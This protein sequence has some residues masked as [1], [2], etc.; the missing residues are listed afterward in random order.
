MKNDLV[1]IILDITKTSSNN[2]L[3]SEEKQT[4]TVTRSSSFFCALTK[5]PRE[6]SSGSNF[7]RELTASVT[8]GQSVNCAFR[9]STDYENSAEAFGSPHSSP[10]LKASPLSKSVFSLK[11][12]L[13][14]GV[15]S[16]GV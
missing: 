15:L 11:F 14:N 10:F 1:L 12:R 4:P 5:Q 2:C 6:L 9:H 13:Q 3:Q 8:I 16:Q 7:F